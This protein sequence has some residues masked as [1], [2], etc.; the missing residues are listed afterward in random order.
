MRLIPI[1]FIIF[2]LFSGSLIAQEKKPSIL[3]KKNQS[4][5]EFEPFISFSYSYAHKFNPNFTLGARAQM[6]FSVRLLLTNPS[7]HYKGDQYDG[8]PVY[9][10]E[11][12]S[13]SN[14][15]FTD[16]F[17]F[18][19]FYRFSHT[20]HFYFDFGPYAAFGMVNE[21][22]GGRSFGAEGSAF[23]AWK[24]LHIGTRILAGWQTFG[25]SDDIVFA[26]FSV[27]IVIGVHF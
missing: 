6:G 1:L 24:R 15:Y 25:F 19:C 5:F 20:E 17:K 14:G 12:R 8:G 3:Q 10:Q 2:I 4:C 22:E 23:F 16:I 7:V 13:F 9:L 27:P 11:V 21:M 26:L 18:Q